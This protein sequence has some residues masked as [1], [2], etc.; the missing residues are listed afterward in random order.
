MATT[1]TLIASSTVGAGGASSID[2]TSIP[3]TYTDL[4]LKISARSTN[5]ANADVL[6]I[7]LS[8]NGVTTNRTYR[9][10]YGGGSS[11]GSDNGTSANVGTFGGGSNVTANT[12]A[13]DEWYFPNYAG[14]NNKS[15]SADNVSETNASTTNQLDFVAGLWSSSSAITS[16]SIYGSSGNLAQYT[17]AYLYGIK[18]S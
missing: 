18:N 16:L 14:S 6:S 4:V 1:Y 8:I 2:F 11:V 12:F 15:F 9:R 13:S 5:N 17:S 10:L 3:S 7:A